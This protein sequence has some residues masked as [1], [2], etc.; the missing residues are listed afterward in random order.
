MSELNRAGQVGSLGHIDTTQGDFRQQIDALTD[1]TRQLG[2]NPNPGDPLNSPFVLYVNPYTGRDTFV[3]GSYTTTD[4]GDAESKFRRIELQRLE[5]G[6][7]EARPFKTINRAVLEAGIITSKAY[8]NL[9]PAP[10]GDLVSIVLAPGVHTVLNGEG[11]DAATISAWADGYEPDAE[12]LQKFN[13]DITGG[14]LL[15]RGCSLISLDLRKCIIRPD[16][17][18]LPENEADDCENRRTIFLTTGGG[19]YYGFTV[20]DKDYD[21]PADKQSHHLL[22]VW[23]YGSKAELDEF[24]GKIRKAFSDAAGLN[25]DYAVTRKKEHQI[26]GPLPETPSEPT[27]TVQGASPY[28]YNCS[29]RSELGMCSIF[30]DGSKSA[31]G[32]FRSL[33]CAQVTGVSLQKDLRAYEKYESGAWVACSNKMPVNQTAEYVEYIGLDP[34]NVRPNPNWRSFHVRAINK[35]VIQEV[36]MFAIGHAIHHWVDGGGEVTITNSNSSFGNCACLA[37]GFRDEAQ[38][39][40]QNWKVESIRRPISPLSKSQNIER[41]QL[42]ILKT[43]PN[44]YNWGT[45]KTLVLDAALAASIT[46]QTQPELLVSQGYSLKK[47]DFIWIDNPAGPDYRAKIAGDNPWTD[48]I[49]IQIDDGLATTDDL[50]PLGDDFEDPQRPLPNGFRVY[51]RRLK[52]TRTVEERRYTFQISDAVAKKNRLPIR[53]YILQRTDGGR[54]W[55]NFYTAVTRSE[56]AKSLTGEALADNARIELRYSK[57]PESKHAYDDSAN[58]YYRK[59]DAIVQNNKHWIANT[60]TSGAFD[61]S[62][63]SESYV[64]MPTSFCPEGNTANST[65]IIIFDGDTDG[66][67]ELTTNCGYAN[68]N[69]TQ[70]Q[71]QIKSATDY[72][73]AY[74]QLR[75]W[76]GNQPG[77][78]TNLLAIQKDVEDRESDLSGLN[79]TVEMRRPSNARLYSHAWEWSGYGSYTKALPDY[80]GTMLP[81]NKFTYYFTNSTGGKVYASGFNEEGFQITPRGVEDLATGEVLSV[82]DIGS[83]D[84]PIV[85]PTQ[86]ESLKVTEVLDVQGADVLGLQPGIVGTKG[87]VEK[88]SF[89]D[90]GATGTGDIDNSNVITV[91]T[92]DKWKTANNLVS[93]GVTSATL[94]VDAENGKTQIN[95]K[96]IIKP[97]KQTDLNVLIDNPPENVEARIKSLRAA[98][99]YAN[100]V[101]SPETTVTFNLAPGVYDEGYSRRDIIFKTRARI[102][103]YDMANQREFCD[104][105]EGGRQPFMGTTASPALDN[106]TDKTKQPIFPSYVS[107]RVS[108]TED[109]VYQ[110]TDPVNFVFTQSA[111]ILGCVWWGPVETILS[112]DVADTS[113][114]RHEGKGGGYD[115]PISKA[116]SDARADADKTKALNYFIR[117]SMKAVYNA[118][119]DGAPLMQDLATWRWYGYRHLECIKANSDQRVR[120]NNCAFGP[121]GTSSPILWGGKALNGIISASEGLVVAS[122]I[123][124][125]GQL[126]ISSENNTGD[127]AKIRCRRGNTYT[128]DTYAFTGTAANFIYS[129][130][131]N[132]RIG[133]GELKKYVGGGLNPGYVSNYRW[134][135]I[136]LLARNA[137]GTGWELATRDDVTGGVSGT[138]PNWIRCGPAFWNV[139]Y[140]LQNL[141]GDNNVRTW[142]RFGI[143]EGNRRYEES[144][145]GAGDGFA[146]GWAGMFGQYCYDYVN[147]TPSTAGNTEDSAWQQSGDRITG[148]SINS[149]GFK[150]TETSV[151]N[152]GSVGIFAGSNANIFTPAGKPSLSEGGCLPGNQ[153]LEDFLLD[154]ESPGEESRIGNGAIS[155]RLKY[156]PLNIEL[157]GFAKGCDVTT[158]NIN[159]KDIVL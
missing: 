21:D 76:N 70:I 98:V 29:I 25:D 41:I 47:N 82:D 68:L 158:G 144:S 35:A 86:F 152:I 48:G 138:V 42:G 117:E 66:N 91:Q 99:D 148:D 108:N 89:E 38:V 122:G 126:R 80:Q 73:G 155:L 53:D 24:Y 135:N 6:Y 34:N 92:L 37:E 136:N 104:K 107:V 71:R 75:N 45:T 30:A 125:F 54:D 153:V 116:R 96:P 27:D 61:A 97:N 1:I 65:P 69:S 51:I 60:T 12:E 121:I 9:D 20:F 58:G 151:T 72:Q 123:Y 17:V 44:L 49:N 5:C 90:V 59:G 28:I 50:P 137:T 113:F 132:L 124:I 57:R 67:E 100:A 119:K 14:L 10:C 128:T 94:F 13:T 149:R 15:P 134:N 103:N 23:E 79:Y 140:G 43:Q 78:A 142:N 120:L 77:E 109:F 156:L 11:G 147:E 55:S 46:D 154:P 3:G 63:W 8:F 143:N 83:P 101:F 145:P 32:G 159:Y 150:E 139:V 115:W 93:S 26:V 131:Q 64:H 22:H 130:T 106:Y 112:T 18:P 62:K 111:E 56:D 88:A 2:G 129:A 4:N 36:S 33:V 39:F 95:G 7:T 157:R 84:R 127:Y 85:I 40:D 102:V 118:T 141:P 16:A 105:M 114:P 81:Q 52:D 31:E 110:Q 19:Y 74:W 87:I 146:A 133:F